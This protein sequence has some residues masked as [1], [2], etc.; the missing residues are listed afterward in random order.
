LNR[1][2]KKAY[3]KKL[4]KERKRLRKSYFCN[5]LN[6][7]RAGKPDVTSLTWS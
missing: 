1:Y 7:L 3:G 4:E 5:N 6:V 2:R